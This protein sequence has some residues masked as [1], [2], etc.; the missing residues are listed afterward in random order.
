MKKTKVT[1]HAPLNTLELLDIF[2]GKGKPIYKIFNDTFDL[3]FRRLKKEI[4]G[5]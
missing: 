4:E 2:F 3:E 5:L 1:Y